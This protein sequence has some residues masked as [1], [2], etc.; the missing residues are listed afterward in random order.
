M[1]A[2]G[3]AKFWCLRKGGCWNVCHEYLVM[4][5]NL[6]GMFGVDLV[7]CHG[8]LCWEVC[9]SFVCHWS[10]ILMSHVKKGFVIFLECMSCLQQYV[11]SLVVCIVICVMSSC[12]G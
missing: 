10:K 11:M 8:I 4:C 2:Q 9:H 7:T 1:G 12:E 6:S 3:M 5:Q